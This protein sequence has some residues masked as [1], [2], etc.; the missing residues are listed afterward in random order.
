[1]GS[2][3]PSSRLWPK[4]V[5]IAKRLGVSNGSTP[6]F[7][8]R[9]RGADAES[10][11]GNVECKTVTGA[12]ENGRVQDGREWSVDR[13]DRGGWVDGVRISFVR[14]VSKGVRIMP[15]IPAAETA[16]AKDVNGEGDDNTSSPPA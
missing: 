12:R 15:A 14:A 9:N 13:I 4:K 16:T 3:A 11:V 10:K 1:M 5:A 7:D 2:F 6:S 8:R